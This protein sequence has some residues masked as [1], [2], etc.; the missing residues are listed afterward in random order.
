[1]GIG[2]FSS[3]D[4]FFYEAPKERVVYVPVPT[5]IPPNKQPVVSGNPNPS[6]FE[7]LRSQQVGKNLVVELKYP[8]CTNFEGRKIMVYKDLTI[9]RLLAQKLVDPHFSNSGKFRS[10]IARFA[11]TKQGWKLAC[12]LAK[13]PL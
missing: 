7:V 9:S 12:A 4:D 11:P 5:N 6:N 10:P 3:G 13:M 8:D 2:P 1:M